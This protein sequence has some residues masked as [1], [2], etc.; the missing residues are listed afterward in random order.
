MVAVAP[1]DRLAGVEEGGSTERAG[2]L[3]GVF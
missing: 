2:T 3:R 1:Q